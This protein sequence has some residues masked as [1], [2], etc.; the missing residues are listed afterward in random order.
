MDVPSKRYG[1]PSSGYYASMTSNRHP[2]LSARWFHLLVLAVGAVYLLSGAFHDNIWFDESYSVAIANYSFPE[3]WHITS[4]DVHPPLYYWALHVIHLFGGDVTAYRVF[5][6]L[7]SVAM[8]AIGF[9]HLRRDFGWRTGL[10]F[11]VIA[12]FTPYVSFIAIEVRMYAWA[13]CL[14]MLTFVYGLRIIRAK[15]A[16]GGARDVPVSTW[17]LFAVC[18]LAAA[19]LHYFAVMSAFIINL[20]VLACLLAR[21]RERGADLKA[22]V[23]QAAAQVALYAPWLVSFISQLGVVSNTYWLNFEFPGTLISLA[24]YPFI[25]MQIDFAWK[26]DYGIVAH[27]AV[28][29]L[30]VCASILLAALVYQVVKAIRA[31]KRRSPHTHARN[32]LA[33]FGSWLVS[34]AVLPAF[35]GISVYLGLFALS[36]LASALMHSFMVYFRYVFIGIGP[37]LFGIVI[38]LRRVDSNTLTASACAVLMSMSLVGQA[39][40]LQDDYSS[41]NRELFQ[42]MQANIGADDLVISSDIGIEG[43]TSVELP[44]IPQY[45]MEWQKGNWDLAYSCYEPTLRIVHSWEEVLNDYHGYFWV[46]GQST[47]AVPPRDVDDLQAKDGISL[48]DTQQFYRPYERGYYTIALLYEE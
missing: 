1:L 33:R 40:I 37:F 12:L 34:P 24:R 26:G 7:G 8:A 14:I 6:A 38:I 31:H 10:L 47:D 13:S 44:D 23:I 25:T 9:T 28:W 21:R 16:P 2:V 46:L 43:V 48:I 30:I 19:Y 42:Y 4:G 17:V 45:Y 22:F 29:V 36:G 3:I 35:L 20:E 39:L 18:S 32:P 5:T 15:P 41:Q 11:S 27:I